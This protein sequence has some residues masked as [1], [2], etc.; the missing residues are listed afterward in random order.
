[1]TAVLPVEDFLVG[2]KFGRSASAGAGAIFIRN[3]P[4]SSIYSTSMQ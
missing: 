3:N 1:M 4:R 2:A